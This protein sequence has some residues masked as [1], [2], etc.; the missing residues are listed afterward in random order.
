[1]A[2]AKTSIVV[3]SVVVWQWVGGAVCQAVP[4][5]AGETWQT[6]TSADDVCR[7]YPLRVRRLMTSLDFGNPKLDQVKAALERSDMPAACRALIDYYKNGETAKWLRCEPVERSDRRGDRRADAILKDRFNFHS[8]VDTVPRIGDGQLKWDHRGTRDDVEWAYDFNRHSWFSILLKAWRKTGNPIYVKAFD[9]VIRDWIVHFPWV[10]LP[11][12]QLHAVE[13]RG[14]EAALRAHIWA[15]AFYAFQQVEEFSEAG[16][17]LMLSSVVEHGDMLA[18][19]VNFGEGWARK[20]WHTTHICGLAKIAV[21]WPEMLNGRY[22]LKDCI[23][24]MTAVKT[25]MMYPDG[26]ATE[27]TAS[28]HRCVLG[29]FDKFADI[30][31]YATQRQLK[32]FRQ[33]MPHIVAGE[34]G[35][36]SFGAYFAG[37][38]VPMLN[39]LAYAMRPDGN[40]LLNNDSDLSSDRGRIGGAAKK[41]D[42][43]D[44]LYIATN[45][46]E[47]E[48]PEGEPSVLFPWAGHLI[49]RSGWDKDA[50]WGYFDI[51][52]W[53][54]GHQHND[55]LHLSVSAYGRDLLVD[56]GRFAYTG[57]MA[58]K[59]SS[60]PHYSIAHNVILIDGQSQ[61]PGPREATEPIAK[62]MYKIEPGY[63]Y[64]RNSFDKFEKVEGKVRHTRAVFYVRGEF[65]VVVDRI[66]TDRPRRLDAIWHWHPQCT[67]EVNDGRV[68]S[69][70]KDKGNLRIVPLA[71]NMPW[72]VKVVEGQEKPVI[73]GWY[74][75]IYARPE[76][77]PAATYSTEINDTAVFAWLLLPAK[78]QVPEVD[79]SIV[80]RDNEGMT[81]RVVDSE[82]TCFEVEVSLGDKGRTS[83]K[84]WDGVMK[85]GSGR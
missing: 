7:V 24:S 42:R 74:C 76:P 40:G 54:T 10:R 39:Y 32:T 19:R 34:P 17:I 60:Y 31:R 27:L 82:K 61:G 29:H 62:N 35:E 53:G 22:W 20:N 50:H 28:Y 72:Q 38:N 18:Q 6:V 55:K 3:L 14:L 81:V 11:G 21:A 8:D 83:L 84:R 41:Y 46:Q 77:S 58:K 73:Q 36:L 9:L 79:A 70:D 66:E 57:D 67:V 23:D 68:E 13:S 4:A 71:D 12:E 33:I 65:W 49:M 85:K 25:D 52:P 16:R 63:D 78:G 69:V 45:G 15:K 51:G 26:A 5:G 43:P 47:G 1:M 59:F 48:K 75:P 37:V 44:W 56:T 30:I 2:P 64:A 80:A